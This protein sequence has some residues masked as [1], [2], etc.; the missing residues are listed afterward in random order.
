MEGTAVVTDY[1]FKLGRSHLR[2]AGWRGFAALV[3]VL[4]LRV[5]ILSA[6]VFS[7]RPSGLWLAHL[8]QGSL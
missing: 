2:G 8:F 6:I 7:A 4:I 3:V 1:D 5:A